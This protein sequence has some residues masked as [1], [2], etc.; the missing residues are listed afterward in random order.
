[1][2]ELKT[3]ERLAIPPQIMREQPPHERIK[4]IKEVPFGYT[5][6]QAITEA[7]R[8]LFCKNPHCIEGCPVKIDI[9]AFLKL[10]AEG[11][12]L[13]AAKK[14]KE[15]NYLP[16]IC[17]R[18]CPQEEQCQRVCTV[19]K[20]LKDI[21]KSV[22]I[23]KL[24]RFVAD[25]EMEHGEE[26][27]PPDVTKTGKR[28]AIVGSGPAGLTTAGDLITKGHDVTI[29]EALHRP[30]GVLL[31][32]IPEFRLPKKIVDIEVNNLKK[33]G[34]EIKCNY[35]IGKTKTIP[36]LFVEGYDAVFVGTGA[37]LPMFKKIPGENLVGVYSAN[38]YLTRANLMNAY[39]FP[40]ESDTPIIR[41][42]RVA[43]LGGGNVAMD[44]ART[45]VRLGAEESIIVYRRSE[46]EMPAR[47]EEIQRAKEEGVKFYLLADAT[48]IIGNENGRVKAIE[49]LRM[50]LGEPDE[51]G[52]R[53][54]VPIQNS[55]FIIE[56]DIVVVAIGNRP[57][58]LI[59][60]TTPEIKTHK[61]GGIIIDPLTG[62]TSM[63]GVW[64]GGDIVQGAATVILAMGDG[65]R[66]SN[67]IHEYLTTGIW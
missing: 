4:N 37:G 38:E 15:K 55:E 43:T 17:G 27:K 20:S 48:R 56:I 31:Y 41:A 7:E 29:F 28:V 45:A 54:P 61:W 36:E 33:M 44:S 14:V 66:A 30:G 34:V 19:T 39:K 62:K 51:S 21:K 32:G 52:R 64:A 47:I 60:Q 12:F 23:G 2:R 26:V 13:E 5:P 67:S 6:E 16:A 8:C 63:K 50:E 22:G 65:R 49:C 24:E 53:R 25:Y 58:P 35:V 18:V 59:P 40:E 9:P 46:K 42:K 3:K 1:M 57:N 10:I 11:K